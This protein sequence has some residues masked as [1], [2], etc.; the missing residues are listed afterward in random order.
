M[1]IE[2]GSP[3][4]WSLRV[5]TLNDGKSTYTRKS[6]KRKMKRGTDQYGKGALSRKSV[7]KAP[8]ATHSAKK[9]SSVRLALVSKSKYFSQKQSLSAR[10]KLGI[11]GA[12]GA[13]TSGVGAL[14]G[15]PAAETL[16]PHL[17]KSLPGYVVSA[18]RTA[19]HGRLLK[20]V[21]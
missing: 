19:G 21:L 5:T 18:L 4:S 20:Q 11:S 10:K 2:T 1:T 7:P 17:G 3:A 14:K 6:P 16:S 13:G 8:I 15:L 9:N 12:P